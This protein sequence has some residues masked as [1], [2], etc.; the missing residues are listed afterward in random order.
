MHPIMLVGLALASVGFLLFAG[1]MFGGGGVAKSQQFRVIGE[2]MSGRQGPGRKRAM[3]AGLALMALGL[4]TTFSGVAAR[5][6]GRGERCQA[7]CV[8]QGYT[9]S[10][11]GRAEETP[12]GGGRPMAFFACTCTRADGARTQT[13]ANDL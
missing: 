13:R 7:H 2:V 12:A 5:D 10:S 1:T 6:S 11:L 4:F 8:Q 9:Q 3:G